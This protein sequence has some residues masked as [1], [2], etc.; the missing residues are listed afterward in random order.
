MTSGG[1][2]RTPAEANQSPARTGSSRKKRIAAR[3]K[4]I[5]QSSSQENNVPEPKDTMINKNVKLRKQNTFGKKEKKQI[6]YSASK[7]LFSAQ[8]PNL[9]QIRIAQPRRLKSRP[10]P[11]RATRGKNFFETQQP[12]SP[13]MHRDAYMNSEHPNKELV[14]SFDDKLSD[15]ILSQAN[16]HSILAIS[17]FTAGAGVS[18]G[19]EFNPKSAISGERGIHSAHYLKIGQLQRKSM[20]NPRTAG[21][22]QRNKKLSNYAPNENAM[23]LM[24]PRSAASISSK[25]SG[26]SMPNVQDAK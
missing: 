21:H 14:S 19:Y 10:Q 6:N 22:A 4:R 20:S 16:Q 5:K 13:D 25:N 15:Q 7:N 23:I 17:E 2:T 24:H 26:L 12:T 11:F 18:T 9:T 3:M 1:K 8:G